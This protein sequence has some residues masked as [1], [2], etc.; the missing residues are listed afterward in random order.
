MD[1]GDRRFRPIV[2]GRL[3]SR[4]DELPA[5][6][7]I[8]G[9]SGSSPFPPDGLRI[10]ARAASTVAVR[11]VPLEEEDCDGATAITGSGPVTLKVTVRAPLEMAEV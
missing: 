8:V 1:R 4:P 9:A 3:R 10:D 5:A 6:T 11:M 2:V 7:K